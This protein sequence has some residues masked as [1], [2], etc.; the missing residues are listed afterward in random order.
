MTKPQSIHQAI[1]E[2][3]A[4]GRR[5]HSS[6]NIAGLLVGGSTVY[7][8]IEHG[9]VD[10]ARDWDSVLVVKS[11]TDIHKLI[12]TP[13]ERS[14]L[15]SVLEIDIEEFTS[16]GC[17]GPESPYWGLFDAV[18][19][20]GY[21]RDGVKKSVKILSE[22]HFSDPDAQGDNILSFKD[23]RI[24][25]FASADGSTKWRIQQATR[26]DKHVAILHDDWVYYGKQ[27]LCEHGRD[28]APT[29]FGVTADMIMTGLWAFGEEN[30]GTKFVDRLLQHYK[31]V[32]G[33]TI[34]M[35]VF[36]R[37]PRFGNRHR[38]WTMS[39]LQ[40]SDVPKDLCTCASTTLFVNDE[41][42][43]DRYP[44]VR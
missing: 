7:Q 31:R 38:K 36:A 37:H 1:N 27:E 30:V 34:K 35:N 14:K 41:R 12:N 29:V 4:L 39:R 44:S 26:V 3:Q 40:A 19:F 15:K 13:E 33:N 21:T 10:Q 11:K 32:T 6:L 24:Y 2:L 18:R 8:Q 9:T 17:P 16:L 28:I 5:W 42:R 25:E 22:E 43:S 23:R 20:A